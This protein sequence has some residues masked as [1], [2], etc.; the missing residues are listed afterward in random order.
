MIFCHK[1]H[2]SLTIVLFML[3][4]GIFKIIPLGYIKMQG[5][6]FSFI[7][8]V[9]LFF[10]SFSFANNPINNPVILLSIDGFSQ[11]YLKKYQPKNILSLAKNGTQAKGLIPVFPTKTFPNHLSLVTGVYP[12]KHG[13]VHNKFYHRK[14]NK[15]YTLGAGKN[16]S[17]WLTA[18]PIWTK[19]EQ[20]NLTS[21]IYF[22]PES[23]TQNQGLLPSYFFPY[24]HNTPNIQRVDQ[25]IHWLKLPEDK[26]PHFIA[27]YFST[28]DDA[29]HHYGVDSKELVT[30]IQAIDTLIGQLVAR[31]NNDTNVNANII[32]VSDHGMT[33]INQLAT[34]NWQALLLPFKKSKIIN[35]QT[36]LYV[37]EENQ[38]VLD[39]IQKHLAN[40]KGI[41][42]ELSDNK[43]VQPFTVKVKGEYPTH[44]HFDQL[45]NDQ[46]IDVIPDMVINA[47]APY[48]F[49]DEKSHVGAATHGF[50][51]QLTSDMTAIFIASGPDIKQNLIIESFENIHVY[52][53]LENLL[54]LP[55][56]V[57]V[58]SDSSVLMKIIK[59]SANK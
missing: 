57:N 39:A 13:I 33:P 5:I 3:L 22:W 31:I 16:N 46:G 53:L 43:L 58:D 11:E 25:I 45:T 20:H 52:S 34:I 12:A 49:I 55:L 42:H 32:L 50:D 41:Q 51:H 48:T 7:S 8:F 27:A 23:E 24:Q 21:A 30:E 35:G 54:H 18:T 29:G 10:A 2:S 37:Y 1:K 40:F 15:N 17:A 14:L 19:A 38:T 36:Q 26:R 6:F 47:K 56:S 28:I 44:W 9:L 59:G 4:L